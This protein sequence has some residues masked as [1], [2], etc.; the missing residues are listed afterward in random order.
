MNREALKR[1]SDISKEPGEVVEFALGMPM[2]DR[3]SAK[4]RLQAS[5]MKR[6]RK[7]GPNLQDHYIGE[8]GI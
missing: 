3:R 4:L 8:L 7:M 1:I 5:S 6:E 2:W